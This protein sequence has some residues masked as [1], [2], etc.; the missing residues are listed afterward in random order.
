M[1][2]AGRHDPCHRRPE[3]GCA[4]RLRPR[5]RRPSCAGRRVDVAQAGPLPAS[6]RGGDAVAERVHGTVGHTGRPGRSLRM[7]LGMDIVGPG[8]GGRL[9]RRARERLLDGWGSVHRLRR[10][11]LSVAAGRA[12]RTGGRAQPGR[13]GDRDRG[14]G[15]GRRDPAADERVALCALDPAARP[16]RVGFV[17]RGLG[18]GSRRGRTGPGADGPGDAHGRGRGAAGGAHVAADRRG[19][20]GGCVA[21]GVADGRRARTAEDRRRRATGAAGA[22]R[23]HGVV[24]VGRLRSHATPGGRRGWDAGKAETGFGAELGG[25][26]EYTHRPLGLGIEARRRYAPA[27][28]RRRQG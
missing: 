12:A 22:G 24:A 14:R 21:D 23:P 6:L 27:R 5:P 17:R 15:R 19:A 28:I 4:T 2:S 18:R 20:E 13:R 25:G 26:L 16:G 3:R 8:H 11:R 9:R 10:S 7:D 1:D